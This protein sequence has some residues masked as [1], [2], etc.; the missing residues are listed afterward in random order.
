MLWRKEN[1]VFPQGVKLILWVW[2]QIKAIE[3][4]NK[5]SRLEGQRKEPTFIDHLLCVS[6]NNDILYK[7][8]EHRYL[9]QKLLDIF[10]NSF[11][12]SYIGEFGL[13]T[14]L[15]CS[16]DKHY[17]VQPLLLLDMVIWLC[18]CQWDITWCVSFQE[19][20]L[21]DNWCTLLVSFVHIFLPA[22]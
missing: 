9:C 16:V 13:S 1:R 4:R 22:S 5:M 6:Q 14:W 20:S 18:S 7:N 2:G 15:Q 19:T 3:K 8:S 10:Q 11:F 17:S 12:P 21:R